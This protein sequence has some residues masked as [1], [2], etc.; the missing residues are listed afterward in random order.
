MPKAADFQKKALFSTMKLN[1][2]L[3]PRLLAVLVKYTDRR[4][5]RNW[6]KKMGAV[7]YGQSATINFWSLS[8]MSLKIHVSHCPSRQIWVSDII[9]FESFM[10]PKRYSVQRFCC[11]S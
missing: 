2:D 1:F 10:L 8:P 5:V 9:L 3:D 4:G 6:C 11:P 7:F